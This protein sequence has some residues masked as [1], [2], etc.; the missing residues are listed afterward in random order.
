VFPEYYAAFRQAFLES[1]R[2]VLDEK[3]T[4]QVEK[5]W[6]ATLDMMIV[7]MR[8]PAAVHRSDLA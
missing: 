7:S 3:H 1:A 5:A 6:A 4:P 2:V 8:G